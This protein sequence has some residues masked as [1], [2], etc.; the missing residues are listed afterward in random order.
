MYTGPLCPLVS[1]RSTRD[2]VGAHVA[3]SMHRAAATPEGIMKTQPG[4]GSVLVAS[5]LSLSCAKQNAKGSGGE[6]SD[7]A[8]SGPSMSAPP[9]VECAGIGLD[10]EGCDCPTEG[11]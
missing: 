3:C 1:H 11:A 7:S 9:S 6:T 10:D 5:V 2:C 8:R 4:L